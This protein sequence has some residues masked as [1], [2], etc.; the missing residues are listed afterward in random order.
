M[1]LH[2]CLGEEAGQVVVVGMLAA[3]DTPQEVV[4]VEHLDLEAVLD[5]VNHAAM[6][7][8]FVVVAALLASRTFLQLLVEVVVVAASN[9]VVVQ[10]EH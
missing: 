9:W 6:A 5:Q 3:M 7:A 8:R 10:Q 2:P 1:H 4:G